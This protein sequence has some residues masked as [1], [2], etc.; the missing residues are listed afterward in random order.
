MPRMLWAYFFVI[1]FGLVIGSFLNVLIHRIPLRESVVRPPSHCPGC[2]EPIRPWHNVPVLSFLLLRG[3]CAYCGTRI[4][5]RYPLVEI[6]TAFLYLL[7][8][9]KY[10]F[11][12]PFIVNAVLVSLIL[13]LMLIDLSHRLLPNVLTFP[14]M[15]FGLAVSPL[16]SNVFFHTDVAA[17]YSP[18]PL[19]YLYSL[20][21]IVLGGGI[22]IL[23][24]QLYLLLRKV[25]GLGLGDV[26]MMAMVGA[27]LGWRYAWLSIFLGSFIGAILGSLYI[28]LRSKGS[29]Y[30]LPF[31]SFL[32]VGAIVSV[33]WGPDLVAWYLSKL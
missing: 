18:E 27:F 28:Y 22:L 4:S 23:V 19:N 30:E 6:S 24:A 33:L 20:I 2:D 7:L 11:S 29:R 25:E 32:G 3:R 13:V 10:G 17:P 5:W 8:F 15:L 16:Q 12:A 31:G 21:G 1:A 9:W 26:K 14:G